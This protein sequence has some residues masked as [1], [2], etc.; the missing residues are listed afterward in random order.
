MPRHARSHILETVAPSLLLGV[1]YAPF[2]RFILFSPFPVPR[3]NG[4]HWHWVWQ[5]VSQVPPRALR[6]RRHFGL[7]KAPSTALLA[8]LK[9][10]LSSREAGG[11][12]SEGQAAVYGLLRV[13]FEV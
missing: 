5:R 12:S 11:G 13:I 7:R 2:P 6:G 4:W 9:V 10:A 3:D 1:N 8:V